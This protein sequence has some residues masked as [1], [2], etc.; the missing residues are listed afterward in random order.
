MDFLQIHYLISCTNSWHHQ[1][2]VD[3]P[4]SKVTLKYRSEFL[5]GEQILVILKIDGILFLAYPLYDRNWLEI[6]LIE[7]FGE[8]GNEGG[9]EK[10]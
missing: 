8:I 6:P 3:L 1:V 9:F 5:K 7:M 4:V 2:S 10:W